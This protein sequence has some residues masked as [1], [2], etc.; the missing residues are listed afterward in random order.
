M[1]KNLG[2]LLLAAIFLQGCS[3]DDVDSAS[4]SP[5]ITQDSRF[6]GGWRLDSMQW[7][8]QMHYSAGNLML[9]DSVVFNGYSYNGNTPI[10]DL[11]SYFINGSIVTPTPDAYFWET[12]DSDSLG[13]MVGNHN[14]AYNCTFGFTFQ[15]NRLIITWPANTLGQFVTPPSPLVATSYYHR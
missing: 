4:P 8:S 13:V 14:M 2:L 5:N 12:F 7:G 1:K 9:T 11:H 10:V 3:D 15:G 6:I